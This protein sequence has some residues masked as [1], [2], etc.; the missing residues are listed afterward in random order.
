MEWN[1]KAKAQAKA[2][3]EI[4]NKQEELGIKISEEQYK[5]MLKDKEASL[6]K[7]QTQFK[8]ETEA[9]EMLDRTYTSRLDELEKITGKTRTELELMAQTMGVDL[10]DGTVKFN[11]VLTKLGLNI[12][13]TAIQM[14]QANTDV[15][16][17]GGSEYEK[18]IEQIKQSCYDK[19]TKTK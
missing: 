11:D 5:T 10:Y 12:E 16:I 1:K 15:F 4:Y 9:G 13:K 8:V 6:K 18:M 7:F 19:G 3:E 14:R 17:K 2:L